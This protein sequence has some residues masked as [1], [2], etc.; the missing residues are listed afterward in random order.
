[1]NYFCNNEELRFGTRDSKAFEAMVEHCPT[2]TFTF[3]GRFQCVKYNTDPQSLPTFIEKLSNL[4]TNPLAATIEQFRKFDEINSRYWHG[5]KLLQNERDRKLELNGKISHQENEIYVEEMTNLANSKLK[6][7]EE[8]LSPSQLEKVR[9]LYSASLL[10]RYGLV[11]CI[12]CGELGES[13]EL[14]DVQ[15]NSIREK[16]RSEIKRLEG[17]LLFWDQEMFSSVRSILDA[18]LKTKFDKVFGPPM[19]HVIPTLR[20][21][22]VEVKK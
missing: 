12:A 9:Q 15:R 16:C 7:L 14:S 18:D 5:V 8:V 19:K 13:I 4:S 10:S 17:K 6:F 3:D 11:C 22:V 2:L 20:M 1:L 21:M